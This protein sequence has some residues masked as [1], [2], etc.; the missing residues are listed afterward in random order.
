M[1]VELSPFAITNLTTLLGKFLL[2][3]VTGRMEAAAGL[4][5]ALPHTSAAFSSSTL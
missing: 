1:R 3:E 5:E 4:V 2:N